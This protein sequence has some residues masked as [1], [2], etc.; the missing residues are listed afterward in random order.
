ME[1][2]TVIA[3]VADGIDANEPARVAAGATADAGNEKVVAREL[4][5]GLLGRGGNLGELGA[6]DDR[7]KCPV[8]IENDR[9]LRRSL[10]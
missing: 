4:T 2:E 3:H 1:L 9:G 8:D 6:I 10:T 5:E 7:S